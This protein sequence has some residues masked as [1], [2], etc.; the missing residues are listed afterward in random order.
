MYLVFVLFIL[1]VN[2]NVSAQPLTLQPHEQWWQN[3]A[4][5]IGFWPNLAW[6]ANDFNTKSRKLMRHYVYHHNYSTIL[7]AGCGVGTDY[8]GFL[9]DKSTI[10]YQGLEITPKFVEFG[11]NHGVPVCQASIEYIPFENSSFDITYTRHILEHLSYY[12]KALNELIR[13][14]QREVL[15]VF[16]ISPGNKPDALYLLHARGI[17]IYNNYYNKKKIELFIASHDKVSHWLWE[18]ITSTECFLHIYLK[19]PLNVDS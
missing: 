11:L 9:S 3:F 1:I 4:G 13:V 17:P 18:K 12:H 15:I 7:D 6:W 2:C 5:T 10:T 8:F 19:T 14:A 16:F